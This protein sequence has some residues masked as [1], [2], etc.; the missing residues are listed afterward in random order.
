MMKYTGIYLPSD[1]IVPIIYSTPLN[2]ILSM[3][4]ITS[5]FHVYVYFTLLSAC[6]D[7]TGLETKYVDYC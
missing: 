6:M 4:R 1:T 7:S 3:R 2:K 5:T